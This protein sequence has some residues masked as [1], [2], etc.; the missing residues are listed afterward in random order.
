M[1][2]AAEFFR[3]SCQFRLSS[4]F[5]NG[6]SGSFSDNEA[7]FRSCYRAGTAETT[8]SQYLAAHAENQNVYRTVQSNKTASPGAVGAEMNV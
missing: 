3:K 7:V 2:R 6:I 5:S 8:S 1:V 4:Y